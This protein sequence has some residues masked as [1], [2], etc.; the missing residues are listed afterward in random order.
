M[1]NK[2]KADYIISDRYF[3]DNVVNIN[4]LSGKSEKICFEKLIPKPDFAFYIDVKPEV[5][6]QRERKPDQGMEY[7]K[8]KEKLFERKI[9]DWNMIVINGEKSKYEIFDEIKSKINV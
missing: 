2:L 1:T 3:Y 9:K 7:L 6:M 8:S 5:I 4:F